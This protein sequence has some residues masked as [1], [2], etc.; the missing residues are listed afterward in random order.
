MPRADRSFCGFDEPE[1]TVYPDDLAPAIPGRAHRPA[2]RGG[3][4]PRAK[5]LPDLPAATAA[6]LFHVAQRVSRAVR[7]ASGADAVTHIT[8]DDVAGA[9]VNLVA[10][11]K[12]H[13]IPRFTGD[14]VVMAWIWDA[15]PGPNVRTSFARAVREHLPTRA[16]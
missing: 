7:E 9:G 2:P 15:V 12:R 5:H 3:A 4:P 16:H 1:V 13:V 8:E 6:R 14:A 11:F 10:H